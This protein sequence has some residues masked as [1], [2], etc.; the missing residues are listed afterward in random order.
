MMTTAGHW[1]VQTK[2]Y[3]PQLRPD[4]IPRQRLL[5][6]LSQ[7][8]LRHRLTLIS[9]PAGY[10]KTTLL[11][12]L[13]LVFSDL[14]LF[15]LALD[16]ADN[17]PASFLS[18]LIAALQ[19][20]NPACGV[21]AQT[22]MAGLSNP[23]A[24]WQRVAGVFINDILDTLPDPSL[25]VLDDLHIITEPTIYKI[26]DYLL[27]HLP[28]ALHLAVGARYDPPLSLARRRARGELAE[29]RPDKLRFTLDE[30]T[31][32]FNER[33]RLGLSADD[34]TALYIRTEG[35]AAALRLVAGS[36][37]HLPPFAAR[38]AFITQ[39]A[40]SSRHIFDL[41]AEEVLSRQE[42][43][44]QTFLL[45]TSILSE[46]TPTLC[47]AVTGRP[48]SGAILAELYHRNLFL[49]AVGHETDRS[50]DKGNDMRPPVLAAVYEAYRYQ[51]LFADFLQ[52][53]L[54]QKMPERL[55]ELHRRAAE[56]QNVLTRAIPHYLAAELWN[57][58]AE[59]IEQAGEQLILQ[60]LLAS[61]QS[62]IR[63]LPEIMWGA[64]PHLAYLLGVC[65]WHQR[66][67]AAS[68][69]YLEQALA[70]FELAGEQ[71]AQGKTL[72]Y[73]S[74]LA[75]FQADFHQELTFIERALACPIPAHTQV[76]LLVERARIAHFRGDFA[77]GEL[78]LE[79][80]WRICQDS[81]DLAPVYTL[82][83][84]YIPS[85]AAM[86][87]GLDRLERLCQLVAA[88]TVDKTGLFEVVLNEQQAIVYFYR[89]DLACALQAAERA[90]T[91]GERLGGRPFW[92]YWILRTFALTAHTSCGHQDQAEQIIEQ[93]L[94]TQQERI[95]LLA[96]S[97]PL[98]L[99]AHACWLLNRLPDIHR[100]YQQICQI[101]I[102]PDSLITHTILAMFQGILELA[103][104]RYAAALHAL[105]EA[106]TL[107]TQ[108]PPFNLFGSA[109]VLLAELYLKMGLPEEAL[110]EIDLALS[111]CQEQGA[112]GRIL[113]E[114]PKAIPALRLALEHNR[115][116]VLAGQ[117]LE[118]LETGQ[119][120]E[121]QPVTVLDTGQILTV[122]EVEV[123]C[124]I[125]AGAGNQEIADK[126]VLSIHTVKRHVANILAKLN[127][128]DR[129]RA[130]ARAH[131]LGIVK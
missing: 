29:V 93:L 110:A 18:A 27:D 86:P 70:G 26:L 11:A 20:L 16:E 21:T 45:E 130:A 43:A 108:T 52:Q 56:A 66:E 119:R 114:G 41:L 59:T 68:A 82:L 72:A 85:F 15:W 10:G 48:D 125:A 78:D 65:A 105:R 1:I 38:A 3:P 49:V 120:S 23:A 5:E 92:Q 102:P 88:Q 98:Y 76:Q 101:E 40:R 9:A 19:R 91:L 106:A 121:P 128:S 33:L 81:G 100:I 17:D 74:N 6:T 32:F 118:T 113:I 44:I 34:L 83:E 126:L 24:E 62:W 13:P 30:T 103:G 51:D 60:G 95:N 39:L 47:Q 117:L 7:A 79:S 14:P 124:L 131:E 61:L 69:F 22:V 96:K 87:A 129:T 25:L 42:P 55:P 35:W 104:G 50:E 80:A 67:L 12:S 89:G 53:Q 71:T 31:E 54:A 36:L 99:L 2:L 97:G 90:S 107:E 63:T 64:R 77:Q 115:H 127:V 122:R 84:G 4:L 58:A 46:L 109:R 8:V 116:P 57:E 37:Q 94:T 123:L 112:P 73:L 111:E 75:F 28:P